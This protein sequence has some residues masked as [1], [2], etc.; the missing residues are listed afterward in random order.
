MNRMKSILLS[1]IVDGPQY[2]G[3]FTKKSMFSVILSWNEISDVTP[4]L[5]K[6][7]RHLDDNSARIY[8]A[9]FYCGLNS[10]NWNYARKIAWTHLFCTINFFLSW[11]NAT[12]K[13]FCNLQNN[14]LFQEFF[15]LMRE[16][17]V[18]PQ[19]VSAE[20][21]LFESGKC[22][23]FHICSFHIMAH[24]AAETIEGKKL[25]AEIR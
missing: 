14:F 17:V 7:G 9:N 22:G 23:H 5:R 20:K 6:E 15:P 19:I 16:Y 11:R 25:F 10:Q 3:H 2:N 4:F 21:I 8:L 18:F 24:Y 1:I 13:E 12:S